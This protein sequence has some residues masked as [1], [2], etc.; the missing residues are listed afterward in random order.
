MY[1]MNTLTLKSAHTCGGRNDSGDYK[2][3]NIIFY[4]FVGILFGGR[5]VVF[6]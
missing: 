1:I 6:V 4:C 5:F 2:S 3:L